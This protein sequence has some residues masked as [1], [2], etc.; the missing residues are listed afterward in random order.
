METFSPQQILVESAVVELALTRR[1]LRALPR[2]PVTMI[3]DY[4][5][6]KSPRPITAAK[7]LLTL[8]QG[9]GEAVKPFPKI[10]QAI[11]LND[12]VFNPISNCHLECTYCILQSYLANNPGLTLFPNLD[13][14]FDGINQL[15]RSEPGNN[16]R[17]GTGEL[18]DSLALDDLTQ[19]SRDWVPFFAGLPNAFL[20]FKTKSD[21][22]E[23]LLGLEHRGRTVVSWSLSP[24]TV[25]QQEELKCASVSDRLD[26]AVR[27]QAAGYPVGIHLD[28][29]IYFE[30]WQEAYESLLNSIQRKLDPRRIAWVSIGSLRFDKDLK[31]VATERFG[32]STIFSQDFIAAPDGKMRY[33]KTLRLMMYRWMWQRLSDWSEDFPRY[34]CMEAPW[35]WE[36]VTGASAPDPGRVEKKLVARLND[37]RKNVP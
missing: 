33:F 34:L 2:V 3:E 11:N 23:N 14:F 8:A 32:R 1:V 5:E 7:R 24:E 15:T 22:V 21:C 17:L 36:Q 4:R 37:L 16:F 30:G 20:E 26:A 6:D 12:Y 19:L 27:V 9:R 10:K 31:G 25:A 35:V 18:S 28:P 13:F 29:M